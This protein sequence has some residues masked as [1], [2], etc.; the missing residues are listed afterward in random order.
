MEH[1]GYIM[2]QSK[3]GYGS[4]FIIL[5]PTAQSDLS[6]SAE[7]TPAPSKGSE[8]ILVVDDE[9]FV[10]SAIQETLA[11]HG[12]RVLIAND[13]VLGLDVFKKMSH[14]IALVITDMVM[15]KIDGKE[16]MKRLREIHPQIRLL[17]IS[18]YMKDVAEKSEIKN[19]AWFLQKPFEYRDLLVQ[20]RQ[21][22]DS[23]SHNPSHIQ[24]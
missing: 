12:Y 10:L 9:D 8:T 4:T 24:V 7:Q 11:A 6:L 18:G 13:P 2:I 14:D 17:A 1:K 22:L 21:I 3:I 19:M 20:I 23:R 5:L 15:P 16:F